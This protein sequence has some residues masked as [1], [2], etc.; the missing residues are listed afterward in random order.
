V[1]L[2]I[3][4]I[5]LVPEVI[6]ITRDYLHVRKATIVKITVYLLVVFSG[7]GQGFYIIGDELSHEIEKRVITATYTSSK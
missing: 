3:R 2:I 7:L 6:K 1:K 5:S 4:I